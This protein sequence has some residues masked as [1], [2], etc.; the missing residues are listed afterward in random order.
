MIQ[1]N[2]F[3]EHP[4]LIFNTGIYRAIYENGNYFFNDEYHS[5][6]RNISCNWLFF[7]PSIFPPAK[8][9]TI[10][11]ASKYYSVSSDGVITYAYMLVPCNH[12]DLCNELARNEWAQRALLECQMYD[13]PPLYFTL[14]YNKEHKPYQGL[15]KKEIQKFLKRLRHKVPPFRYMLCGE[16]GGKY[17]RPHYHIMFFTNATYAEFDKSVREEWT[18]THERIV[19]N[20]DGSTEIEKYKK[21]LGF[22]HSKR[23][24][25]TNAAL[26]FK[27]IAKYLRK[28]T[29]PANA[30]GIHKPFF[31]SSRGNGGIGYSKFKEFIPKIREYAKYNANF[32]KYI[33]KFSSKVYS[34]RINRYFLR[35][36]FPS[37]SQM[38]DYRF[39]VA[40]NNLALISQDPTQFAD[41]R[42][43]WQEY[44]S[45]FRHYPLLV[46]PYKVSAADVAKYAKTH[47]NF[48]IKKS[49]K[50]IHR[51]LYLLPPVSYINDMLSRREQFL[52]SMPQHTC[53]DLTLV[54]NSI[55]RQRQQE[56]DDD[57]F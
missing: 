32:L 52:A 43:K 7:K 8:K 19:V 10:E 15:Q 13:V 36:T 26:P 22:V 38:V 35:K 1:N 2:T 3:C 16:Y 31:L 48:L 28:M 30:Q 34:F 47:K 23:I 5:V 9:L 14:T 44:L 57:I 46:T 17:G 20:E 45:L 51:R 6:S 54:I 4:Q 33:D 11:Q 55:K 50:D 49:L 37:L 24:D 56:I 41:V 40:Y 25:M 21:P 27:Y 53:Q 29:M 18:A 12:C 39:R 42:Q